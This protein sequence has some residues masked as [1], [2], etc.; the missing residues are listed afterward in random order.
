MAAQWAL[1]S[2]GAAFLL[3]GLAALARPALVLRQFGISE[4]SVDARN[5]VRA[6]Y[7]GFGVF[8]AAATVLAII[9]PD[10]RAGIGTTLAL[11]LGGMAFGRLVGWAVDRRLGRMPAVYLTI[12]VIAASMLLYAAWT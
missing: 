2:V 7:G 5:E 10:L 3:M 11:A 4:L 8:T 6:V 1:A 12:E 9:E